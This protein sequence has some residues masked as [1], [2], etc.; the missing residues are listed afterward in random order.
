MAIPI[1]ESLKLGIA[2]I[3]MRKVRSIVTVI[4]IILGVMC[5]M[6]V[7]AIV[8]GMNKST[9]SWMEER[10]GLSKIEVEQNWQY[11]F[12]KGG[13]PS[14]RRMEPLNRGCPNGKS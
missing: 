12:S 13:D 5:I 10:G 1:A 4:G 7:L 2:D 9:M 8:N 6:V 3:L 14:A 11:D